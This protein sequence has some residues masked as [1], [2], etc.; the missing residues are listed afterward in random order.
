ML[1]GSVLS[2]G[3]VSRRC[4]V[5]EMFNILDVVINYSNEYSLYSCLI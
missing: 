1:L 3:L 2:L 4:H 5:E